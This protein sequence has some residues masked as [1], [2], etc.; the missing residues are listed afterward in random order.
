MP[1]ITAPATSTSTVCRL[2]VFLGQ[3]AFPLWKISRSHAGKRKRRAREWNL[4]GNFSERD[5][6]SFFKSTAAPVPLTPSV[7]CGQL[8]VLRPSCQSALA[9]VWLTGTAGG[10][11]PSSWIQLHILNIAVCGRG[12]WLPILFNYLGALAPHWLG[13]W[14]GRVKYLR[15][16]YLG[17][18]QLVVRNNYCHFF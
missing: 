7:F 3:I 14:M 12:S 16:H 9:A 6:K 1:R 15:A 4:N 2:S 10:A 13:T 17:Y 11:K 8:W 18:N 5:I